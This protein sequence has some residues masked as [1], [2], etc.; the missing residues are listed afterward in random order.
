[1]AR[2]AC[3]LLE[4]ADGWYLGGV[5]GSLDLIVERSTNGVGLA[6]VV[7]EQCQLRGFGNCDLVVAVHADSVVFSAFPAGS[8][9]SQRDRAALL[10]QLEPE[11]P[12]DAEDVVADFA[13]DDE[14][15]VAVAVRQG[16]LLSFV[17]GIEEHG[18]RV[19][20]LFPAAL[21]AVQTAAETDGAFVLRTPDAV[22]L[23]EVHNNDLRFWR[24][25]PASASATARELRVRGLTMPQLISDPACEPDDFG[26][27]IAAGSTSV[28]VLADDV[29][30]FSVKVLSGHTVPWIELRRDALANGDPNRPYRPS[31]NLV[32]MCGLSLLVLFSVACWWRAG[33]FNGE[34]EN[35][36]Q[37]QRKLYKSA[38]PGKRLPRAPLSRLRSEHARLL[39][40]QGDGDVQLPVSAIEPTFHVLT[41]LKPHRAK[42]SELRVQ[43]GKFDL[44]VQMKSFNDVA[45]LKRSMEAQ[46]FAVEI[47]SQDTDNDGFVATTLTGS[48]SVGSDDGG[49]P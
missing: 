14:Q 39:G 20:S 30:Q 47:G 3:V 34:A 9:K 40:A 33:K 36:A 48:P 6:N 7:R 11:L 2:S 24:H 49:Q 43:D 44:T 22:E 37:Q 17:K 45:A 16:G 28:R 42:V 46:G 13:G 10:Y 12:F 4:Q 23:V 27:V 1:M 41:S 35:Y 15:L 29:A 5:G 8:G 38:F 19:Q 21:A 31:L 32:T 18:L 25:L 26:D